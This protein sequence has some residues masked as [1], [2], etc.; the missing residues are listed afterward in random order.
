MLLIKRRGILKDKDGYF[1]GT[2]RLL[3]NFLGFSSGVKAVDLP[4]AISGY[5][6]KNKAFF[7]K[8]RKS[9]VPNQG[10]VLRL[11]PEMEKNQ[12]PDLSLL[13][14]NSAVLPQ[15]PLLR[16]Q[17]LPAVHGGP[18][19]GAVHPSFLALSRL[20]GAQQPLGMSSL[21]PLAPYN[22]IHQIPNIEDTKQPPFPA[23]D[24]VLFPGEGKQEKKQAHGHQQPYVH[25]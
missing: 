18:Q 23:V 24:F 25:I 1:I 10:S 4:G 9:Y 22:Q 15:M 11:S 5:I 20:R 19:M 7:I 13:W 8:G 12:K 21:S 17:H 2:M 6:L 3:K 16:V 14:T